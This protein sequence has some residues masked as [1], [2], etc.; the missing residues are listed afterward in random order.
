MAKKKFNL[1]VLASGKGTNF[2]ALAEKIKSG[3]LKAS[4]R[5]LIVDKKNALVRKKAKKFKIRDVFIDPAKYKTRNSYDKQIKN[6]LK[7]EKIDLIVL[8]GFMRILSSSFV[9]SFKYKIIN[10]HPAI[11]PAF[12]GTDSIKRTYDYG[13]KV[14]GVTVHYVDELIDH[15]PII[16]QEA[17]KIPQNITLDILEKKIH[18]IEHRLLPLAVKLI[19]ERKAKVKKRKVTFG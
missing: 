17:I 10:V 1:A 3:Y 7:K 9:R 19:I 2:Q 12:K 15:G 18:K 16:F 13:C 5:I 11:L 6:I 4:I 14:A 8:A